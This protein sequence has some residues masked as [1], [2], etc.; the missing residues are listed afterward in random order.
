MVRLV[1]ITIVLCVLCLAPGATGAGT[2]HSAPAAIAS[3]C[4]TDVTQALTS[5]IASVPDNSTLVFPG[6]ACYR[7]EGTIELGNRNGLR[8]E[9]GGATFRA[10]TTTAP[11][12]RAQWRLTR[13][14]QIVLREMTVQGANLTPGTFV[15]ALQHQ[16]GV[17]IRGTAGVELDRVRIESPNGDCVYVGQPWSTTDTWSSAV[18]VHDGS[19]TGAG[20]NGV[21]VTAGRNVL[22]ETTTF[23]RI[24]LNTFDLEPNGAGFGAQDVT[25]ARNR[26][27]RAAFSVLAALGDAPVSGI[28]MR[29]N[30]L[31][32]QSLRVAA[33]PKG[34]RYA[35][36]TIVGNVS[37]TGH[38]APGA[39]AMDFLR[40]DGL[41]VTGNTVPLSGQNMALVYVTESCGVTVSGNVYPG[42]VT[43]SRITPYT[44]G[45]VTPPP[46]PPPPPPPAPSLSSISPT[47][48]E[49]GSTVTLRGANLA[50]TTA[51]T[52]SGQAVVFRSVSDAELVVTVPLGATSG[53]FA[54][55]TPAGTTTSPTYTV[56]AA[57]PAPTLGAI[58]PGSGPVGSAVTLTG[59]RLAGTTGVT[60]AGRTAA[61][62]V[63]SDSE[64]VAIVPSG[65]TS[66]SFAVTTPDGSATSRRFRVESPRKGV[67]YPQLDELE[68][69]ALPTPIP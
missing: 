47:T 12:H 48:G 23:A 45:S 11:S 19:C 55:T 29:E 59:T 25:F 40:I 6:S 42:G 9:G 21:A 62:R 7:I 28:T 51:V 46:P 34:R 2:T 17:D 33:L 37:D 57:T 39:T 4:S 68:P 65:A 67:R 22:V 49:V 24:G 20:R 43:E 26:I 32:G 1:A 60:L 38:N 10:T 61:F 44:C 50:G 13:G 3:D 66:G 15:E 63:V 35:G 69:A 52:L 14:S 58:A 16:H 5:W 53:S 30:T 56:V 41:A 18:Y 64:L 31:V 54:V 27:G 8:F 36:F